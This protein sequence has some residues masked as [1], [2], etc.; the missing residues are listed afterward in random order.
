MI[1][2]QAREDRKENTNLQL[3]RMAELINQWLHI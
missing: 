1:Y 2:H 3:A